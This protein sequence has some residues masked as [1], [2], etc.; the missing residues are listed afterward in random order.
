MLPSTDYDVWK[1]LLSDAKVRDGLLHDTATVLLIVG[2][3]ERVVMQIMGWSSTARMGAP[4]WTTPRSRIC[5][6]GRTWIT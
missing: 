3:P 4:S 5:S 1:E 6:L 2:V